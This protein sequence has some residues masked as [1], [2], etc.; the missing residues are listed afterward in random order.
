LQH[1]EGINLW[2]QEVQWIPNSVN[3]TKDTHIIVKH[4][5]SKLR[6]KNLKVDR[7]KN[8]RSHNVGPR[9]WMLTSH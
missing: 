1:V 9:E 5:E 4:L 2:I 8:D 7:G 3:L 6:G